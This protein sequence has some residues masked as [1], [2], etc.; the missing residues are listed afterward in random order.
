MTKVNFD[1]NKTFQENC[2]AFLE[3]LKS[4]DPEM[5]GILKDH[6]NDLAAIRDEDKTDTKERG[7]VNSSVA[8][9]LDALVERDTSKE[10]E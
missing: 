1:E 6:W 8:S 4:A 3:S 9:K 10:A 7:E 2:D 5:A